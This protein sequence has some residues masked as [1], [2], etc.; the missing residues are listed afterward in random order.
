M[1]TCE[2]EYKLAEQKI[3]IECGKNKVL[4]FEFEYC[5]SGKWCGC[6]GYAINVH[7]CLCEE[8]K[9]KLNKMEE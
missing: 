7:E 4:N 8:C 3:C 9:Q 5:C 2:E 1:K 6:Y